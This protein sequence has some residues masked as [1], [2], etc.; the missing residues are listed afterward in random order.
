MNRVNRVRLI[1]LCF[2]KPVDYIRMKAD[3]DAKTG[4][5]VITVPKL[6]KI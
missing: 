3:G 6:K 2:D 1:C 5:V 4:R